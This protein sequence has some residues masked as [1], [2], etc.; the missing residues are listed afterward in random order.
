MP[1]LWRRGGQLH[2]QAEAKNLNLLNAL[3]NARNLGLDVT[4]ALF[5]ESGFLR[6]RIGL[7]GSHPGGK[8]TR[9]HPRQGRLALKSIGKLAVATGG[10]KQSL[11]DE[12][13]LTRGRTLTLVGKFAQAQNQ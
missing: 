1:V 7:G 11:R 9:P 8:V 6:A 3:L 5:L 13:A 10:A 2:L 12:M 4:G